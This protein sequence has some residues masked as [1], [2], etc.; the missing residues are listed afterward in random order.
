MAQPCFSTRCQIQRCWNWQGR[1]V[2]LPCHF[3]VLCS[4][5]LLRLGIWT[6]YSAVR[7]FLALLRYNEPAGQIFCLALGTSAGI[8]SFLTHCSMLLS[9]FNGKVLF[10]DDETFF[11]IQA[12]LRIISSFCLLGPAVVNLAL[13]FLWKNS[14]KPD[15]DLRIRCQ[16]DVDVVWSVKRNGCPLDKI[17]SSWTPWILLSSFRLA[18]TIL[19]I[20]SIINSPHIRV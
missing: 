20:A 17:P 19:I 15:F 16:Y 4:W 18:M 13:A 9:I 10:Q 7:Y 6:T 12:V 2:L 3:V 5:C 14:Q 11:I 8:A 1:A